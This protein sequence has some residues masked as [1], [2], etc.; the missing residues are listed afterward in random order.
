MANGARAAQLSDL[1]IIVVGRLAHC[2][3]ADAEDIARW[4]GL[5]VVVAEAQAR[6]HSRR[7]CR[8]RAE[9][10]QHGPLGASPADLGEHAALEAQ[11]DRLGLGPYPDLL[12]SPAVEAVDQGPVRGPLIGGM[13]PLAAG[14]PPLSR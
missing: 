4:L 3:S 13:W 14:R 6:P 8:A 2:A 12:V 11:S 7:T 1:H 10:Q 5:P 9:R